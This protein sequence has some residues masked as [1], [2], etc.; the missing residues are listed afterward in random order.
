MAAFKLVHLISVN[1][2]ML[3]PLAFFEIYRRLSGALGS[4]G[5]SIGYGSRY[6][7]D[8]MTKAQNTFIGGRQPVIE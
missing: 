5:T 1:L 8:T 2:S 4:N 3:S 7:W 6:F